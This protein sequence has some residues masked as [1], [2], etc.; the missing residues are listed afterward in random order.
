VATPAFE[1][2][3][4]GLQIGG[5]ANPA[6]RLTSNTVG[7]ASWEIV[8]SGNTDGSLRFYENQNDTVYFMITEGGKVFIGDDANANVTQGLTINQAANDDETLSLKSSDVAHGLTSDS[9]TD[10]FA[11]FTKSSAADGGLTINTW[12]DTTI[13]T[14]PTL[15]FAVKAGANADT[16]KTTSA[17]GIINVDVRQHTGANAYADVVSDG[18][19][20]VM[21]A[22]QAGAATTRFVFDG[23]GDF[24]L[25]GDIESLGSEI[26]INETGADVDFRIES[27]TNA[28][29]FVSDA[30]AFTGVGGYSFGVAFSTGNGR[31]TVDSP[32]YT[33]GT[34]TAGAN[35]SR[36]YFG[37]AGAITL[38]TSAFLTTSTMTLA[39]PN[40]TLTNGAT[41]ADAYT[42]R[43]IGAPT[44]GTRNGALWV[45]SGNAR[46]DTS[47]SIGMVAASVA[48]DVTGDIEYTGTITDVSDERLKENITDYSG[49]LAVINSLWVK[50]YNMISDPGVP[51]TGF[52]AQN[53]Q[54]FFPQ[55]VH[56]VDPEHGYLG[57]SYVSMIPV[58]TKAIQELDLKIEGIEDRVAALEAGGGGGGTG[59]TAMASSFFETILTNVENG[60]GYMTA[61]VVNTLTI[62]SAENPTGVTVY[63]QNGQ[64]GCL[65]VNDVNTGNVNVTAGACVTTEATPPSGG[66][67]APAGD[68]TAPVITLTGESNIN[69]NVGDS[70][71]E[72]GATAVDDVDG[73]VAVVISGSVD[74][75]I[76]GTYTITYNASDGASNHAVEVTR[77]VNVNAGEAPPE[78]PPEEPAP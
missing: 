15:S 7:A 78:S 35:P 76:A 26:A 65:K 39:E 16:A 38:D 14:N 31:F 18:N 56:T 59:L 28:N 58:I 21:R 22:R 66:G 43:I 20:L 53:V 19:L 29:H 24:W 52:I 9:E 49:G 54:E 25:G 61:L 41:V 73:E 32:A 46:F 71:T 10:T 33:H 40:I 6:L 67:G 68:T 34:D 13:S 37:S 63:D 1:S 57:V 27:D 17:L 8:A 2:G 51:E 64:V 4:G 55:A 60:V 36:N 70:Y 75:S 62:G 44:E 69:L 30:G 5:V 42:L 72:A 74:T 23:E 47:V 50:S 77:T 45:T 48:L 11:S 3:Q 12:S